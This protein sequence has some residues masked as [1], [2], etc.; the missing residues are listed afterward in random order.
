MTEVH[1][2][3]YGITEEKMIFSSWRDKTGESEEIWSFILNNF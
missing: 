1:T 2:K 3:F